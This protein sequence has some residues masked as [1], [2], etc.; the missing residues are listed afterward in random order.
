VSEF[1]IDFDEYKQ[2]YITEHFKISEF[3]SKDGAEM[4]DEV[5]FNIVTLAKQLEVLRSVL[6]VPIHINSGYRSTAYNLAVGGVYNS[7]HVLGKA[8]DI[9]TKEVRPKEIASTLQSLMRNGDIYI[10]GI[11]LYKTFVHY[12]IRLQ[13]RFWYG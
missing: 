9:W 4:S 3:R 13:H 6:K 8:A 2:E 5:R 1:L 10:G 7:Y 11:G 12:D